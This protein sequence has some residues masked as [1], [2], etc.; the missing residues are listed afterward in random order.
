MSGQAWRVVYFNE[1]GKS[2]TE[3]TLK[4]A[5]ERAESLRIRNIVVASYTGET[6]LKASEVFRG[7]NLVIVAGVVGFKEPNVN[8]MKPENRLIIEKNGGKIIHAAHAFGT[9]GRAIN[10]KFGAIQV[11]EIIANV[12]RLFSQGVKVGCEIACMAVDAG[13]FRTDEEAIS[14]AGS[15][16]GA[17]TAIVLQPSNTHT[18]F[19]TRVKEIICKPR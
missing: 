19:E 1:P 11:D 3:E 15:G 17:D 4:L 14:I 16:S 7:Y 6:G 8:R 13:Y 12:L 18:F 5:K 9:L 10:R 2:N